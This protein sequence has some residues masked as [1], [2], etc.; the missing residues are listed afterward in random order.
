MTQRQS[1]EGAL[2]AL[3]VCAGKEKIANHEVQVFHL[4]ELE[5]E[6]Q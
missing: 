2:I 5:K 4:K 6:E 1:I 3:N